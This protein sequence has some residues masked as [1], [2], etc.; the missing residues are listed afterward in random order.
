MGTRV[1]EAKVLSMGTRVHQVINKRYS[2]WVLVLHEA[3]VLSMGTSI[4]TRLR[5]YSVNGYQW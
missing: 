5:W 3:K 2:A 1:H 4:Y